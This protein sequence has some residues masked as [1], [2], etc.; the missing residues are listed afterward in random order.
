M[1]RNTKRLVLAA[2]LALLPSICLGLDIRLKLSPGLWSVNP[3]DVNTAI[4]GWQEALER[5]VPLQP[6][7]TLEGSHVETMRYGSS[8]EAELVASVTPRLAFGFSAGYF[9][10]DLSEEEAY[11]VIVKE[12]TPYV[13]G[14]PT[15]INAYPFIFSA[16]IYVPLGS[17]FHAYLRG[18]GGY[19]LA[20]FVDRE[21]VK[22]SEE[23]TFVYA[24]L[25]MAKSG[26]PAYCG[27]LGLAYDFDPAIGLYIEAEARSAKVSGFKGD[28]A[29][30]DGLKLYYLEEYDEELSFWQ[31]KLKLEPGTPSTEM[32]RNV[33][34]AVIDFSGFSI[35]I[36][37]SL[38]F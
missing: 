17:K 8:L 31:T 10:S 3:Q 19:I 24:N 36:G 18:G 12:G 35:K 2:C 30:G 13:H 37:L 25:Q 14:H 20:K 26:G 11:V 1:I 27:G 7:W 4:S 38:K 5:R 6:N 29:L 23:E 21:A 32:T 9:Y 34:E 16:Y 22:S 33:R 28:E 15:K